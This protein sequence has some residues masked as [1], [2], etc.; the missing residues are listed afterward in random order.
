MNGIDATLQ[1]WF[2]VSRP[3]SPETPKDCCW[4]RVAPSGIYIAYCIFFVTFACAYL[5]SDAISRRVSTI[6]ARDLNH[7]KRAEWC[8]RIASNLHCAVVLPCAAATALL[9]GKMYGINPFFAHPPRM[10]LLHCCTTGF[11]AFD[12]L[13]VLRHLDHKG[14]GGLPIVCHHFFFL[15]TCQIPAHFEACSI[16]G[17]VLLSGEASTVLINL[18]W[19]LKTLHYTSHH[20]LYAA[21]GLALTLVFFLVRLVVPIVFTVYFNIHWRH[22]L[23]GVP[24]WTEVLAWI[25]FFTTIALNGYWFSLIVQGLLKV[26]RS[27]G[28]LKAQ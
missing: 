9:D 4:P 23:Q 15:L 1:L 24:L 5:L 13:V 6:Y 22:F 14:M 25:V 12:L 8:S 10:S 17:I 27:R 28:R 26:L 2:P 3:L 18:R 11:F 21:N 7:H 19:F 16:F 20:W